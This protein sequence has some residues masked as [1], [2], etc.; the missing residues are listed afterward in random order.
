MDHP[1]YPF[2]SQLE[3]SLYT[4]PAYV[5]PTYKEPSYKPVYHDKEEK[6]EFGYAVS[7]PLVNVNYEANESRDGY[8]TVGG[9]RVS[10]PDGRIQ[11][12]TYTADDKNGFI[13][14][15]TYE[16]VAKFPPA[17]PVAAPLLGWPFYYF[18]Y[19]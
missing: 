17:R 9:Y 7:D 8:N 14:K 3:S 13:A 16:G 6:Y 15:V 18:Q 19:L 10:L 4:E 5:A 11:T 12:V 2:P 1:T